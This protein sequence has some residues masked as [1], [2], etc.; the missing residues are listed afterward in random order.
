MWMEIRAD[1]LKKILSNKNFKSVV[2][3]WVLTCLVF[4]IH[5]K[6]LGSCGKLTALLCE[7]FTIYTII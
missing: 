3:Y 7:Q 5:S 6:A 1:L 4:L 2:T